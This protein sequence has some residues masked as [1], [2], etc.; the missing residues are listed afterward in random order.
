MQVTVSKVTKYLIPAPNLDPISVYMEDLGEHRGKVTIEQ[1]GSAYSYFWGSTGCDN[2]ID[3]FMS[4]NNDYL[5]N[6]LLP[7]SQHSE[8][9]VEAFIRDVKKYI[10]ENRRH[11]A[12]SKEETRTFWNEYISS[13]LK[14]VLE[15]CLCEEDISHW[16]SYVEPPDNLSLN[17]YDF[18]T[19]KSTHKFLF[20]RDTILP[21]IK[22][23]LSPI[24]KAVD[25]E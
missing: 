3:F 4:C 12:I 25:N 5:T 22:Q 21:A 15:D 14:S 23:A 17:L 1:Y 19:T 9:D 16:V 20:P 24:S 13:G 2:I 7:Y 18:I 10:L 6:K 11:G 8:T